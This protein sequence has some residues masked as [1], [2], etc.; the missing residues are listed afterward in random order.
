MWFDHILNFHFYIQKSVK[1][2]L[3]V[4]GRNGQL[5]PR[6]RRFQMLHLPLVRLRPRRRPRRGQINLYQNQRKLLLPLVVPGALHLDVPEPAVRGM[7]GLRF[8][9][10]RRPHHRILDGF[11]SRRLLRLLLLVAADPLQ[12]RRR[13]DLRERLRREERW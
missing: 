3:G 2:D 8:G 10:C 13:C 1:S 5:H 4:Q 11:E 6:R 12:A 7:D 9:I